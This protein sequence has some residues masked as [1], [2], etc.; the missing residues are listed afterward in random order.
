[1]ISLSVQ[2]KLIIFSFIFGF[3]FSLVIK[4]F[5]KKVKNYKNTL[6]IFLSFFLI[7]MM[8]IIYFI[9]IQEISHAILHFYSIICIIIGFIVYDRIAKYIKK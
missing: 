2:L 1:M 7:F 8:S 4:I 9:G 5:N 6:K 3:F